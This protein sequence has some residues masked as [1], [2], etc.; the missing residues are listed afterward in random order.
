MRRL[1][2]PT[3]GPIAKAGVVALPDL[4]AP[5]LDL[6]ARLELPEENGREQVRRE[7]A[8][9]DVHPRVFVDQAAEETAAVC[10]F[11]ADDLGSLHE[12]RIVDQQCTALAAAEVLRLVEAEGGK[13]SEGAEVVSSVAPKEAV[14][15]VLDDG[16][17]V[18]A[19]QSHDGVHLAADAGVVHDDDGTCSGRDKVLQA[20]LV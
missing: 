1:H 14:G 5:A 16:K 6:L 17:S 4:L 9:A 8:G 12:R 10:A 13:G 11:L 7:I 18:P 2:A 20:R 19:R 3:D 15:V